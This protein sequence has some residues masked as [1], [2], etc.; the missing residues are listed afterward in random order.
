M[1][2]RSDKHTINV[3]HSRQTMRKKSNRK[4][5]TTNDIVR[6]NHVDRLFHV[7]RHVSMT[8]HSQY[9][10]ESMSTVIATHGHVKSSNDLGHTNT[11]VKNTADQIV[12]DNTCEQTRNPLFEHDLS[13]K[14]VLSNVTPMNPSSLL[15]QNLLQTRVTH[16]RRNSYCKAQ[17]M[18]SSDPYPLANH[19]HTEQHLN[20]SS[21][22][23]AE[24]VI[25]NIPNSN[26]PTERFCSVSTD[27]HYLQMFT[28]DERDKMQQSS[29]MGIK[30]NDEQTRMT[31]THS[32]DNPSID[33]SLPQ[34][35]LSEQDSIT[36]NEV[37]QTKIRPSIS[38]K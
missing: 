5:T 33:C 32:S 37:I 13:E 4:Q 6:N 31:T 17:D 22:P 11:I 30:E 35:A 24:F 1:S 10:N 20:R 23:S 28:Y 16:L 38:V 21:S 14:T 2:K 7:P 9:L 26:S 29:A 34:S 19:T 25:G 36:L 18:W 12:A 27:S 8:S 3:S 15:A